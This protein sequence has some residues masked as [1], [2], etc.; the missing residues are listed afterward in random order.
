[1]GVKGEEGRGGWVKETD[2]PLGGDYAQLHAWLF[3]FPTDHRPLLPR[4]KVQTGENGGRSRCEQHDNQHEEH[5]SQ[6]QRPI[7]ALDANDI[8]SVK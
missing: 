4:V 7:K 3:F 2:R 5:T 1:M 8:I 6:F